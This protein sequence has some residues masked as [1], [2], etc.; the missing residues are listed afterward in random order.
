MVVKGQPLASY[1]SRDIASPQQAYLYAW[2]PSSGCGATATP[3]QKD[4]AARQVT[5]ARDYL[6]FLGLTAPQ[7][8]DL[9]RV[10]REEREVTLGAPAS[11]VVLERNVS[12]GIAL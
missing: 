6:E 1:Y 2:T 5:Q 12:E 10:R 11:G 3:A 4:L 9:A 8:A 7:I